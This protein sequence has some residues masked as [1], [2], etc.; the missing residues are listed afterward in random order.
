MVPLNLPKL[1]FL[2]FIFSLLA[3]LFITRYC[4]FASIFHSSNISLS[5]TLK[6][7]Y[8]YQLFFLSIFWQCL[9]DSVFGLLQNLLFTLALI[10][11]LNCRILISIMKN[12]KS[13]LLAVFLFIIYI[14]FMTYHCF[15][16]WD[17]C[18]NTGLL[19]TINFYTFSE[20]YAI[21]YMFF[22]FELINWKIKL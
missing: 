2:T 22:L 14:L 6:Y 1:N 19:I 10:D 18:Y 15:F 8:L 3:N 7:S 20:F 12:L 9:L 5:C 11:Q 21:A 13:S 4:I 17:C 16:N